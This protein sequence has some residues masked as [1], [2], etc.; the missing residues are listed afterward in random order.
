M[1]KPGKS[2][3]TLSYPQLS[4]L[5]WPA[6]TSAP[7]RGCSNLQSLALWQ[8]LL[9]AGLSHRWDR[10]GG[11]IFKPPGFLFQ[12]SDP[13]LLYAFMKECF[14]CRPSRNRRR[15]KLEFVGNG[16]L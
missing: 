14:A 3:G 2:S 16:A 9:L 13:Q 7:S 1:D 10:I 4:Q 12:H 6:V 11:S 8:R 5:Y 15:S